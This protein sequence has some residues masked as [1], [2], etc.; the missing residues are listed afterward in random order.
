[1]GRIRYTD[2]AI[3]YTSPARIEPGEGHHGAK[4][5][6]PAAKYQVQAELLLKESGLTVTCC[7]ITVSNPYR[8]FSLLKTLPTSGRT[9]QPAESFHQHLQAILVTP[10]S[11]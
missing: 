9:V 7:K 8:F 10:S 4:I 2:T 1:M 3:D 11:L 6:R 5:A